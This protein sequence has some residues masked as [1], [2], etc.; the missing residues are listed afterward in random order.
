MCRKS[1]SPIFYKILSF[2]QMYIQ[3]DSLS[4]SPIVK[5]QNERRVIDYLMITSDGR[6]L[7]V[8]DVVVMLRYLS[9]TFLNEHRMN[10]LT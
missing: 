5:E 8:E 2:L 4:T 10:T 6:L 3:Y 7:A 1:S 9:N